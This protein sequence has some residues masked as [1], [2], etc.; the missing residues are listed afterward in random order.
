MNTNV[1][2]LLVVLAA[3][4]V[5]ALAPGASTSALGAAAPKSCS[6][7]AGTCQFSCSEGDYVHV[8]AAGDNAQVTGGPCAGASAHC[9]PVDGACRDT[10]DDKAGDDGT[11]YC[12]RAGG[13]IAICWASSESASGVSLDVVTQLTGLT[14]AVIRTL[15]ASTA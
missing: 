8:L 2:R 4:P 5:L 11:G 7:S 15:L 13:Q 12:D 10:S 1:R 3:V 9:G 14:E 6:A